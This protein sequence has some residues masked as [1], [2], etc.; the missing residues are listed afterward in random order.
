MEN[1]LKVLIIDD[2][3]MVR[4]MLKKSLKDMGVDNY[5][6]SENGADAWKKLEEARSAGSPFNFI[7]CDWNMPEMNGIEFLA[8]CRASSFYKT[9]PI[10][11]VTAESEQAQIVEALKKGATDYIIKPIASEMLEKK[12][13]KAISRHVKVS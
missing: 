3:E 5:I 6:E 1:Q 4:M 8:K 7:F 9:I 11:M 13:K 10:I 12:V 2:F